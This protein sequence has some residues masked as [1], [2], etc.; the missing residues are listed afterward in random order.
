MNV[1][2]LNGGGFAVDSAGAG[3]A[4]STEPTAFTSATVSTAVIWFITHA[5]DQTRYVRD[6]S[7]A[8]CLQ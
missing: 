1:G 4:L 2:S 8:D 7:A 6:G 3:G 5:L